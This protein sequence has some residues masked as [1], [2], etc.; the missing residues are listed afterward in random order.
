MTD[1]A[2]IAQL[3]KDVQ[4]LKDINEIQ[5]LK[6][7]YFRCVDTANLTELRTL[8]HDDVTNDLVG[9]DYSVSI[10]GADEFVDFIRAQLH[11]KIVALHQGHHPEIEILSETEARGSWYLWDLF[12]DMAANTQM[13]GSALYEDRYVKE[14]GR[15][16]IKHNAYKRVFEVVEPLN[17]PL[18]LRT[19]LLG[20]TGFKHPEDAVPALEGQY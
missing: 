5:K 11:S 18:N 1:Q 3:M 6:Y 20:Q 7:A 8:L 15:W 19:H 16:L 2:A 4:Q 12:I 13:Y 17:G 9:G 10:K 14:N